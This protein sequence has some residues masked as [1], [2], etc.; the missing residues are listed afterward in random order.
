MMSK[1]TKGALASTA[2][3][4][5][6]GG[7]HAA[8][9]QVLRNNALVSVDSAAPATATSTVA[10]S[11]IG[12]GQ[13]IAGIDYRPANPRLLYGVSNTGQVYAINGFTGAATAV[14]T[15][16]AAAATPAGAGV[17]VDFNP[18]V[19]RIRLVTTTG[20]DLRLNPTTGALAATDGA[21][22]YA[23]I[24]AN[25]GQAPTIAGSAYTNNAAGATTSRL[26]EIAAATASPGW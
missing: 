18:T 11:G 3:V 9:L 10:L 19:D 12:S 23:G 17:G 1:L 14:G 16:V 6:G 13:S 7:A 21:P 5:A 24:D 22:M 8:S 15:G 20:T 2:L 4:C 25:A 26:Y